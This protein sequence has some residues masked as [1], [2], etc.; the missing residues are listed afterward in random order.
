MMSLTLHVFYFESS[1]SVQ[2]PS[3]KFF[4]DVMT[5]LRF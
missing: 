1:I 3:S 2:T 5:A 4:E